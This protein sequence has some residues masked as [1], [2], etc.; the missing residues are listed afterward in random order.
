MS[1]LRRRDFVALLGGAAAWPLAARA[2]QGERMRHIGVLMNLTA[3]D[4]VDRARI[5]AF[6]QRLQQLGWAEDRNLRIEYR[7]TAGGDEELS[8][9]AAALV[10]LAPEVIMATGSPPVVALRKATRTTPIVFVLV[11]DPV[12]AGF[13]QSLAKPGGNATGFTPFEYTIGAKWLELLKEMAPGVTRV[14]VLRDQSRRHRPVCGDSVCSVVAA[15]GVA[16]D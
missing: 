11:A 2:Q 1:G 7:W 16:T 13:V 4:A 5:G 14:A 12:G 3:D 8:R 6:R 10:A 15:G 9:H